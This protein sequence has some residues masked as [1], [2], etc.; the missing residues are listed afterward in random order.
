MNIQKVKIG[1]DWIYKGV[2]VKGQTLE[3]DTKWLDEI[4]IVYEIVGK[5]EK[6]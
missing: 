3:L 2:N 5:K 4:G 1:S 6:E